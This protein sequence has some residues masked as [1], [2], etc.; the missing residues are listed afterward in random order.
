MQK[1]LNMDLLLFQFQSLG[2]ADRI[3]PEAMEAVVSHIEVEEYNKRDLIVK[4]GDICT[5]WFFVGEGIVRVFFEKNNTE[6]TDLIAPEGWAF[7]LVEC[8]YE[9]MPANANIEA[10]EPCKI[11][12]LE[13]DTLLGLQKKYPELA[14]IT[15]SILKR[16][17]T[18]NQHRVDSLMFE[19]AE[20]KYDRLLA[21]IP[22][23]LLR[24]PSLYVASFL[25]ITPE[26]LSRVRAKK[27]KK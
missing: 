24:V 9:N 19:T 12:T 2:I 18:Y 22:K 13:K 8:Y 10:L 23:I 5:K 16:F 25:G 3:P 7:P 11:L 21:N 6:I 14:L 26:T 27:T 4:K 17:L 20:E 15:R 1:L